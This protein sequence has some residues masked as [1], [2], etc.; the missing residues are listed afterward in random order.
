MATFI[1]YISYF[2]KHLKSD[3]SASALRAFIIKELKTNDP[4]KASDKNLRNTAFSLYY[5]HYLSMEI[6]MGGDSIIGLGKSTKQLKEALNGAEEYRKK[7]DIPSI[8][9]IFYLE[10]GEVTSHM[11]Q[12]QESSEILDNFLYDKKSVKSKTK[13][14][15]AKTVKSKTVKSSP[16]PKIFDSKTKKSEQDKNKINKLSDIIYLIP[17]YTKYSH[18]FVGNTKPYR[19]SVFGKVG[20]SVY[21]VTKSLGPGWILKIDDNDALSEIKILLKDQGA[22]VLEI[23]RDEYDELHSES[24]EK[25]RKIQTSADSTSLRKPKNN[26]TSKYTVADL[27]K[28]A[29]E[30]NISGRSKMTKEELYKALKIK[31]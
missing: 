12:Y 11:T 18:I 22:K 2:I 30:K 24:K 9:V 17:N 15:K 21:T 4:K 29:Q 28:M 16:N 8:S 26:S 31:M 14:V 3:I 6:C 23:S 25:S 5:L 7:Y 10:S 13:T 27:R 20:K 19:T 1:G